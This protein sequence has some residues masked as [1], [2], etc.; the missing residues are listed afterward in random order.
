MPLQSATLR[1]VRAP[2]NR[3]VSG[4]NSVTTLMGVSEAKCAGPREEVTD[5]EIERS[6]AIVE[7]IMAET[8]RL[9]LYR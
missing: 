4:P 7:E 2:N 1:G 3:G 5:A 8:E 6:Q 9:G